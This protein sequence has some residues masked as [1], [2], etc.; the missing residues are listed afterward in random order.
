[1]TGLLDRWGWDAHTPHALDEARR[2]HRPVGV[3][4]L[5]LDRFKSVNDEYGHA[6][7]DAVLSATAQVLRTAVRDSDL[8]ARLGGDEFVVLLPGA[9]TEQVFTVARRISA[10][11]A[12]IAL[13]AT[14]TADSTVTVRGLTASIGAAVHTATADSFGIETLLLDADTALRHAKRAGRNTIRI[15]PQ[16]VDIDL[17]RS[18]DLGE[19]PPSFRRDVPAQRPSSPRPTTDTAIHIGEPAYW[20]GLYEVVQLLKGEWVPA[21]LAT[22]ADGPRH[23]T[24]ILSTIH[25]TTIGQPDPDRWLHDSILGRTLRRM[26]DKNLVTRHEQPARFPKSTVY[27]L[28]PLA[29][30]LL[31]TLAPA[32]QWVTTRTDQEDHPVHPTRPCCA[33]RA[34]LRSAV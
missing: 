1:M 8:V 11:I 7:G 10:R 27:E 3:L 34:P 15:G 21:I 31:T 29:T 20:H 26:E 23:F 32:V 6:A 17:D 12:A 14:V 16:A 25:S 9:D 18:D 2:R 22:L 19:M 28:T 13:D 33:D 30:A 4:A 5:D 24:E